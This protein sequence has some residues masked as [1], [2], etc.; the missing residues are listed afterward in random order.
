MP[1][2]PRLLRG[3]RGVVAGNLTSELVTILSSPII[4]IISGRNRAALIEIGKPIS[5]PP[6]SL[7]QRA[8]APQVARSQSSSSCKK[9]TPN[10]P[11]LGEGTIPS[12]GHE[13]KAA[14]AEAPHTTPSENFL[15]YRDANAPPT[16]RKNQSGDS[17]E[18]NSS[19]YRVMGESSAQEKQPRLKPLLMMGSRRRGNQGSP[20]H[21]FG[22]ASAFLALSHRKPPRVSRRRRPWA[23]TACLHKTDWCYRGA[24]R[25]SRIL[26]GVVLR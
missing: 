5:S 4:A 11:I 9:Q 2:G 1:V 25:P 12:I 3:K 13:L 10:L 24:P 18:A 16:D 14:K 23:S 20:S 8:L 19:T 6:P 17:T 7:L 21:K 15:C 22:R 26:R